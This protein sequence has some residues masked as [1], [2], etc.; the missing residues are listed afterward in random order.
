MFLSLAAGTGTSWA[1]GTTGYDMLRLQTLPRGS[2]LGGAVAAD[3]GSVESVFYNPAGLATLPQRTAG[4]A[5]MNYLLDVN[6]GHL[7]YADPR[8]D[9]GVWGVS[10]IYTNYGDFDGRDNN[11]VALGEFTASDIIAGVTYARRVGTRAGVGA[12]GKFIYS[13]IEN[14][15]SHAV[16]FDLGAQYELLPGDMRLG[17]GIYN[18]GVTTQAFVDDPDDLPLYYRIGI[19]GNPKGL[20][21]TLYLSATLYQEYADNYTLDGFGS[22]LWDFLGDFY[23]GFGAEFHP[24]ESFFLRV[25]YNTEGLDQRVDTR[26]DAFAG[27]GAGIGFD[28]TIAR[29]DIGLASQGELGMVQRI[30]VSAG[31]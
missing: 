7:I 30:A 23:Y 27:I 21:A 8:A 22:S 11:A 13:D 31:F 14:Y 19:S 16:A 29:L 20:P 15:T 2:S 4:A 25:G 5:Y 6:S 17:L 3:A 24:V 12:S 9:W 18:L 1:Q 28:F 26:K 10:V